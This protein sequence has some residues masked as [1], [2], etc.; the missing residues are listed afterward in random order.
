MSGSEKA[1]KVELVCHAESNNEE[2]IYLCQQWKDD[3]YT[4][5]PG[6]WIFCIA[7]LRRKYIFL[8]VHSIYEK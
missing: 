6:V 1:Y 5:E 4:C 3:I 7:L 2:V 8:W